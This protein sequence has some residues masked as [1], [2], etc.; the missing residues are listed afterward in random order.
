[1]IIENAAHGFPFMSNIN[2]N[3]VQSISLTGNTPVKMIGN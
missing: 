2:K 3:K 1:M